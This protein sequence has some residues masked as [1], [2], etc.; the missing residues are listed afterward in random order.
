[1]TAI[2]TNALQMQKQLKALMHKQGVKLMPSFVQLAAPSCLVQFDGDRGCLPDR[3]VR[4]V[5]C[6]RELA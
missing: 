3:A 2:S 4:Q 6:V 5:K 1:M